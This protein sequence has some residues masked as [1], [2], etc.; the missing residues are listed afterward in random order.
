MDNDPRDSTAS[1]PDPDN[2]YGSDL[3]RGEPDNQFYFELVVFK[4]II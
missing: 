2:R 4:V 3:R 1:D